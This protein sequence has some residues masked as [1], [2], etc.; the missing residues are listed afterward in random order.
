M[1]E[2]D[3]DPMM[4]TGE[5]AAPDVEPA[6]VPVGH[7]GAR[8]DVA[9]RRAWSVSG[10]I[11]LAVVVALVLGGGFSAMTV[12]WAIA[13][14]RENPGAVILA[15]VLWLLAGVLGSALTVVDPGE[16]RA[17]QLFGRY[18]GTLRADGLQMTF[19][20]VT[21]RKVSVK[22]RNFETNELKVNDADGNPVNIAGIIV[23]QVADTAKA[24]FAVENFT[25]FVAVQSE[26]ALRH[27]A[28]SHPYDN[29]APGE[30]SLRGSTEVVAKELAEEVAARIAIAGLEVVE[31]R[32]SS[33]AYAP[34]IAHAMLQRQ[35]AAAVVAAR[36]QIVEGAV[37]MVEGALRQL[38]MQ[39]VV[40]LDE[41]RKAAMVSNL[42][43]VLCGSTSATPV[44]NTGSLYT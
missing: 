22:V 37:S 18:I 10:L 44:V 42:L 9:E 29:A 24:V 2:Y 26:A 27:V 6:G 23:W 8:V 5:Q 12:G 17:V 43:V 20:L 14:E 25:E 40:V 1:R 16:T 34:E 3:E 32:I 35:Q 15:V 36:E 30:E 28:S 38:E 13:E 31:A 19:P 41:E 11:G 7:A 39:D 21:R 33:L 4:G